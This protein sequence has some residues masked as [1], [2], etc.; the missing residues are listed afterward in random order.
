MATYGEAI[1]ALLRAGFSNRDI[2]DLTRTD[3]REE[4]L[5]LGEDA[6]QEEKEKAK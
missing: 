3:G 6:L 1:K 4:V 2:L 5:K